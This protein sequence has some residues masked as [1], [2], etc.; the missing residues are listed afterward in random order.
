MFCLFIV[1]I[2]IEI[3]N[4]C[5]LL[6]GIVRLYIY[7]KEISL[8]SLFLVCYFVCRCRYF[9]QNDILFLVEIACMSWLVTL[10]ELRVDLSQQMVHR[11]LLFF[12]EFLVYFCRKAGRVRFCRFYC[13]R[14]ESK[15][16][17]S[18]ISFEG[19]NA[20]LRGLI[21]FDFVK[22]R[23]ILPRWACELSCRSSSS[24]SAI[25]DHWFC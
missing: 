4:F 22:L 21:Y 3:S 7:F 12:P 25:A 1:I 2:F 10:I 9:V 16:W 8:L 17:Q 20:G 14:V 19:S 15:N 18:C 23:K 6:N 5:D 13:F 11:T 24:C